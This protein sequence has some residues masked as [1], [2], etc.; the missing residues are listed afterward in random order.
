MN[1]EKTTTKQALSVSAETANFVG[2]IEQLQA[3]YSN[4]YSALE[5]M[6]GDEEACKTINGNFYEDYKALE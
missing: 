1:T 6:Y 3:L 5:A 4:V 2:C